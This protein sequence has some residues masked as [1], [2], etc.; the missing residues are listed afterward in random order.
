MPLVLRRV[1]VGAGEHEA[2]LRPV[3]ERRPHLLAVDHPLVA[4][5]PRRAVLATLARSEPAFGLGVALAP[6]LLAARDP[7]QEPLLLLVGAEVHDRRAEQTLADDADPA[8][9]RRRGRTP[10]RRSPA[11]AAVT[12]RPPYSRRPAEAGPAVARRAPAPTPGAPRSSACSS[13]GPPRPRTTA[14]SPSSAVGEPRPRLGAEALVLAARS[15]G[16]RRE[17]R[18]SVP[19]RVEPVR[20]SLRLLTPHRSGFACR[21]PIQV[22]IFCPLRHRAWLSWQGAPS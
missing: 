5:E 1:A 17:S 20:H 16:P 2:P 21:L 14:N 18:R 9:A 19:L 8:R 3:R 12:S 11:G 22:R 4:V 6:Q 7:G 10:R 15:A 13:P